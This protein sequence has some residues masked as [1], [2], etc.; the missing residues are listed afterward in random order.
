MVVH[1]GTDLPP[2]ALQLSSLLQ[3]QVSVQ[4]LVDQF[5]PPLVL[6]SELLFGHEFRRG[7][8]DTRLDRST[9]PRAL[10]RGQRKI[11][12]DG[13]ISRRHGSALLRD[14]NSAHS[15]RAVP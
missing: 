3:R 1:I 4:V 7:P 14:S 12:S 13:S 10:G 11:L 8:V 9:W 15:T 6:L 2:Q 5:D